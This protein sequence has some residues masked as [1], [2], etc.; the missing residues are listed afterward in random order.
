MPADASPP[1]ARELD[2][3]IEKI[4]VGG[5]GLARHEGRVVFVPGTAPGERHR[6]RV[7]REKK[8]FARARSI[9]LLDASVSRR[10]PPCP[11]YESCGGCALMH[12]RPEAQ[13][14]AKKAVLTEGLERARIRLGAPVAALSAGELGYRNRLRFHVAF[15]EGGPIAGFRRRG[16]HEVVDVE[17]CLLGS[18][19]LNETWQRVR[20][21]L[22]DRRPLAKSLISVEL[23]ESSHEPGRIA[24]RFVVSSTDG[25]RGLDEPRREELR[26][27]IGLAGLVGAVFRGGPVVRT[28]EPFVEHRVGDL[29]LRQSLGS[30]FQANRFL[31]DELVDTVVP[32]PETEGAETGTRGLDLYCGVGLFALPLARRVSNVIGVESETLALRDAKTNAARAG[33]GNLRFIRSDAARYAARDRLRKEDV[34][35]LDPPRGGPRPELVDALAQSPLRTIR[36]VSCDPAALFRDSARLAAHGF[37]IESATLV[38]LFPNTHHFE[39]VAVFSRSPSRPPTSP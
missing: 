13:L 4:V 8:D 23:D 27:A 12:L 30:F 17:T 14:E 11:Y 18:K 31:L 21:A 3:R 9:E 24:A 5:D 35:I 37:A 34:V 19:T 15:A 6:V 20:R 32:A 16:S 33:L 36:Y 7:V 26:S 10:A 39:T 25:L 38:D 22:T 1:G 28:G 2:V 29:T